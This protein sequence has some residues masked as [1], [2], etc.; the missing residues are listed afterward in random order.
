MCIPVNQLPETVSKLYLD[1]IKKDEETKIYE[2]NIEIEST[3]GLDNI[4]LSIHIVFVNSMMC[5]PV[6]NCPTPRVFPCTINISSENEQIKSAING[7]LCQDEYQEDS[8]YFTEDLLRY[9]RFCLR[10]F[11]TSDALGIKLQHEQ[12]LYLKH[13][14]PQWDPHWRLVGNNKCILL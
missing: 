12:N 2:K 5:F 13:K 1:W 7:V 11:P 3:L 9:R 14:E 4:V 6:R 8:Y 10:F